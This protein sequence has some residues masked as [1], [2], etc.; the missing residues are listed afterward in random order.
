MTG[1]QF[2]V[3]SPVCCHERR[4]IGRVIESDNTIMYYIYADRNNLHTFN[5]K[6]IL[7]KSTIDDVQFVFSYNIIYG[8][9]T[10]SGNEHCYQFAKENRNFK[11]QNFDDIGYLN[12][13]FR[14]Y[15][16]EHNHLKL[17]TI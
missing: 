10:F 6:C 11:I 14:E 16:A 13:R 4:I 5:D 15:C 12:H 3:V 1:I 7:N 2:D 8:M 9:L 17:Q